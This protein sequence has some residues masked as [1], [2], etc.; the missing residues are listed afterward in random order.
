MEKYIPYWEEVQALGLED[1]M[2][3]PEKV[4]QKQQEAVTCLASVLRTKERDE[5]FH[6]LSQAGAAVSPVYEMDEVFSDSR[7]LH[8]QM[9]VD[10]DHPKLGKVKQ[11]GI[12]I[13]LA[14]TPGKIR[15]LAPLRGEHTREILHSLGYRKATI[16]ALLKR[17]VIGDPG[18]ATLKPRCQDGDCPEPLVET[19]NDMFQLHI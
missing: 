10:I 15:W 19:K 16:E 4:K 8:R 12:P 5:W 18:K 9:V 11:V 13:K 17:Q 1:S 14:E 7:V 6:M 2:P 3:N